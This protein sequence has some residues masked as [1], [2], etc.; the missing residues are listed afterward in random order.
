[1]VTEPLVTPYVSSDVHMVSF[2]SRMLVS[3]SL[4][5]LVPVIT[6][7][8]YLITSLKQWVH[9]LESR[10][11]SRHLVLDT[12]GKSIR[13]FRYISN[14]LYHFFRCSTAAEE[15]P[16]L[17]ELAVGKMTIEFALTLFTSGLLV[18]P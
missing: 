14:G 12:L 1:M 18:Q 10:A 15:Q 4:P 8:T 6:L 13:L 9:V 17:L 16:V 11:D 2:S 3:P 7:F 5:R